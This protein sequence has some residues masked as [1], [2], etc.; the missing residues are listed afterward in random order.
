MVAGESRDHAHHQATP[1]NREQANF[2]SINAE[3][4]RQLIVLA[5]RKRG[6][7]VE[8]T[9]ERPTE[10]RPGEVA[11]PEGAFERYFTTQTAW[12]FIASKLEDGH[13][14]EVVPLRRPPGA[15]GYV[16]HMEAEAGLPPI[17]VKMELGAGKVFGRSFHYSDR[18]G[19]S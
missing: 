4:R 9:P 15:K 18:G 10:W 16:M 3:T 12:E 14:V 8:F 5:R 6:R 7:V 19:D 2:V 13:E 17:Y 11:N 1:G